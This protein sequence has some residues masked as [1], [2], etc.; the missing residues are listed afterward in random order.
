M[1]IFKYQALDPDRS[2]VNGSIA[3][4]SP[5]QARDLLRA[6]GLRVRVVSEHRGARQATDWSRFWP[7]RAAAR[8]RSRGRWF[9]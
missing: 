3:A 5:R 7:S 9:V 8:Q 4:D 2:A 6:R 1:A